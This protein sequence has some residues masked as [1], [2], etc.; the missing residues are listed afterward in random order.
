MW[1]V[2]CCL[3]DATLW[4]W[5]PSDE[6]FQSPRKHPWPVGDFLLAAIT[7]AGGRAIGAA[8]QRLLAGAPVAMEVR[9]RSAA[10]GA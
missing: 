6:D 3:Q 1:K 10:R 9:K 7:S 5:K 8:A 4:R 2:D